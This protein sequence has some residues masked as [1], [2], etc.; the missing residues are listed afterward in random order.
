MPKANTKEKKAVKVIKK[1]RKPAAVVNEITP[2]LATQK[3]SVKLTPVLLVKV[4]LVVAIGVVVFLL[5]QKNRGFILAGTVNKSPIYRWE[6]NQKMAEK[7]GETTLEEIISERLLDENLA[8]NKITVTNKEVED[9]L[10]SIKQ[11]YG[12]DAQFQAAIKQYGMTEAQALASI[13]QS[14]GLKKLIESQNK[15]EITDDQVKKYFE[16]NKTSFTGK[17]LEDVAAEI[18][19]TLYQQEIYTK[20]QEWYSQVRKDAKV[21]SYL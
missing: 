8:K 5:L 21:N 10:A 6:L 15:I 2:K 7:Y 14:V 3:S 16:D 13:K 4:L 17:K 20:S 12:G 18:K 9:E 1:M 19:T 11:Q